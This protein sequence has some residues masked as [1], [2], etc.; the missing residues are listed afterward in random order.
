MSGRQW[1]KLADMEEYIRKYHTEFSL[2]DVYKAA[3]KS[4]ATIYTNSQGEYDGRDSDAP[5]GQD[6]RRARKGKEGNRQPTRGVI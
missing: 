6:L 2:D 5:A 4:R 1:R 3:R